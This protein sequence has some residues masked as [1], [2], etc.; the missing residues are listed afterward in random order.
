[1][2]FRLTSGKRSESFT[3]N[4]GREFVLRAITWMDAV[5]V[6]AASSTAAE[7]RFTSLDAALQFHEDVRQLPTSDLIPSLL[8]PARLTWYPPK[9]IEYALDFAVAGQLVV[10]VSVAIDKYSYEQRVTIKPTLDADV[11]PEQ[12]AWE[13]PPVVP[14]RDYS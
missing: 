14:V 2:R 12:L 3:R 9:P 11:N 10:G 7:R 5:S 6:R 13:P 4:Y 1:M 8:M